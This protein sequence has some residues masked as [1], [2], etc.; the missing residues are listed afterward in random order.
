MKC[1]LCNVLYLILL[2][3]SGCMA[4]SS[5]KENVQVYYLPFDYSTFVPT[6]KDTV[7]EEA[8]CTFVTPR[9]E[10]DG[11]ITKFLAMRGDATFDNRVVRVELQYRDGSKLHIDQN[12][13]IEPKS[14]FRGM[15]VDAAQ[16][17]AFDKQLA[18][19]AQVRGCKN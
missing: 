11:L 17:A 14:M 6:T 1:V 19:I 16:L 12:G 13:V 3:T 9:V 7:R 18:R 2:L 4:R 5:T 10:I 8:S 15:D